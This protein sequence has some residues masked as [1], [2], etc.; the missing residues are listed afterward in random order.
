MSTLILSLLIFLT[1]CLGLSKKS[2]SLMMALLY[3]EL[4]NASIFL[5]LSCSV[6]LL[7]TSPVS[8]ILFLLGCVCEGA[9][10]LSV[11]VVVAR[12]HGSDY[13]GTSGITAL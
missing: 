2:H 9:L 12:C 7:S 13:V 3:L 11:L 8:P 10:G 5:C 1:A 6:P 4:C